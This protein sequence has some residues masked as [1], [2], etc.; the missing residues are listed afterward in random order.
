M[1]L[2]KVFKS[3]IILCVVLLTVFTMTSCQKQKISVENFPLTNDLTKK[4]Y[5]VG[6][7][8]SFNAEITNK[9]GSDVVIV[10]NGYMPCAYLHLQS[11]TTSHCEFSPHAEDNIDINQKLTKHFEYTPTEAGTYVLEIHYRIEIQGVTLEKN[12][13]NIIIEVA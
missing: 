8:I 5:S 3:A 12:L 1:K 4:T 2:S 11:D 13:D 10:S 7:K 6:E 9:S